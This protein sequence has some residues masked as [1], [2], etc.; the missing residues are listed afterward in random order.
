MAITM[1]RDDWLRRFPMRAMCGGCKATG[2]EHAW[3]KE[4]DLRPVEPKKLCP[5]CNGVG[6]L[7]SAAQG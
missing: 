4:A 3:T 7:A 1:T 2:L 5:A 6:Y